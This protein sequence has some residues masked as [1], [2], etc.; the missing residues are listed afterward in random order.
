MG[1]NTMPAPQKK[2]VNISISYEE[3]GSTLKHSLKFKI[4]SYKPVGEI[5]NILKQTEESITGQKSM[6]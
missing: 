2:T 3:D 4:D 6:L 1:E 5:F